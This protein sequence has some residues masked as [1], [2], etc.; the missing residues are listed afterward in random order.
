MIRKNHTQIFGSTPQNH[1]KLILESVDIVMHFLHSNIHS[2]FYFLFVFFYQLSH[3]TMTGVLSVLSNKLTRYENKGKCLQSVT[4]MWLRRRMISIRVIKSAILRSDQRFFCFF[5]CVCIGRT[6]LDWL[7][8][9]NTNH[10]TVSAWHAK[11]TIFYS[12]L[13]SIRIIKKYAEMHICD[14]NVQKLL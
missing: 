11:Q 7:T 12:L 2:F 1:S 13:I 10:A 3:F 8:L 6:D 5:Y 9:T 4:Q 14:E